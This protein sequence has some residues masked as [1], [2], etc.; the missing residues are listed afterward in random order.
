M[1]SV[2]NGVFS[3]FSAYFRTIAQMGIRQTWLSHP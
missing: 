1:L 2:L 3:T